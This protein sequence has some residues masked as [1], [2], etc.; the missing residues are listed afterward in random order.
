MIDAFNLE[1]ILDIPDSV[2][3]EMKLLNVRDDTEKL[4]S[5]FEIKNQLSI[6]EMIAGLYRLHN[7]EKK[8]AWISTTL[9]NLRNKNVVKLVT[10]KKGIHMKVVSKK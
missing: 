10:G 9:Y 2:K 6:D 5:L 3:N 7:L 4:L 8:R 1:N